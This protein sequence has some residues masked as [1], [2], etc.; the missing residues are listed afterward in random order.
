MSCSVRTGTRAWG[1]KCHSLPASEGS[2]SWGLADVAR[3]AWGA[4]TLPRSCARAAAR[5][6]L[7]W[8]EVTDVLVVRPCPEQHAPVARCFIIPTLEAW[9]LRLGVAQWMCLPSSLEVAEPLF[10]DW[11]SHI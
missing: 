4:P 6:R 7:P 8:M 1:C 11:A 2:G 5:A 9:P 3:G 10:L